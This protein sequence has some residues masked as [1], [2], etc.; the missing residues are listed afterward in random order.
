M[1]RLAPVVNRDLWLLGL[2]ELLYAFKNPREAK[3]VRASLAQL[4]TT[5]GL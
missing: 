5:R 2:H 1:F 4:D 3:A